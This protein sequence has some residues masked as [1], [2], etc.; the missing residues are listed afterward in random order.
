MLEEWMSNQPAR[1]GTEVGPFW[2]ALAR[3]GEVSIRNQVEASWRLP[4]SE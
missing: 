3:T 4:L 2:R 1:D